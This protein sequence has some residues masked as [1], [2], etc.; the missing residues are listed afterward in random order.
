MKVCPDAGKKSACPHCVHSTW[1]EP[2]ADCNTT[3]YGAMAACPSCVDR[4]AS[5]MNI[6]PKSGAHEHCKRC[7]HGTSHPPETTCSMGL[8]RGGENDCPPCIQGA[9]GEPLTSIQL[10]ERP[11]RVR[12]SEILQRVSPYRWSSEDDRISRVDQVRAFMEAAGAA[13]N[14]HEDA[15]AMAALTGVADEEEVE[16]VE[17]QP[18]TPTVYP[19]IPLEPLTEEERKALRR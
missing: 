8:V 10:R 1:H 7:Y 19:Y 4:V 2:R 16:E 3:R 18:V 17:V 5:S 14:E 13:V 9:I 11:A 12:V 15:L 6:C